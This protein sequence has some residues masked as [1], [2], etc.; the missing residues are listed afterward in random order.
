MK[1]PSLKNR[2]KIDAHQKGEPAENQKL[3]KLS[4]AL[5]I[6]FVF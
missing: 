5:Y 6:G 2:R 3:G 1:P 4:I